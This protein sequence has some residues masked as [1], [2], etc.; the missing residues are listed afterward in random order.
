MTT[1]YTNRVK[2]ISSYSTSAALIV[3]GMVSGYA[4]GAGLF[5]TTESWREER[6]QGTRYTFISP[7]LSCD[8]AALSN[9]ST[10]VLKTL[11]TSLQEKITTQK[12]RG[13]I[14]RA[15]VYV[16]EL[17]D[18]VW[19]GINE[20]DEFTPGSLLKVPAVM[21]LYKYAQE[22]DPTILSRQ[23]E[24]DGG[25]VG[26]SQ[27]YPPPEA[28]VRG[29][30]YSVED[31]AAHALRYSDNDAAS[32][33]AQSIDAEYLFDAYHDLGFTAPA[34]GQDYAIRVKDYAAFFRLL[35]NAT[36]ISRDASEHVLQLLSQS[37]FTKGLVAGVPQGI[38]VSHKF[39][40]RE[41]GGSTQQLHD[42]G[43]V[44]ARNPYIICVFS[45]GPS[46]EKLEQFIQEV[47]RATYEVFK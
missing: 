14:V 44:Y 37:S 43:I 10:G 41:V 30:V 47:S 19:L 24:F 40:E 2:W 35:F 12:S 8:A 18:G 32:L 4:L 15:A 23:F 39:G 21:S 9:T 16:R 20:R 36:Y 42:C 34:L 26:I 28:L 45:Q 7:L 29:T 25:G 3:V 46:F 6:E 5:T 11:R 31:M 13:D 27:Q 22:K 38:I 33:V 17:N 1:I